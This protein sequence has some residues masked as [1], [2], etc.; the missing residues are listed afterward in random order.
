[1][2][3]RSEFESPNIVGT[4][5]RFYGYNTVE[6]TGALSDIDGY[7]PRV[8]VNGSSDSSRY[9]WTLKFDASDYSSSYVD[10]EVLQ[11]KALTCLMCIKT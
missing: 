4:F 3:L 2:W 10:D 11:P 5:D 9:A 1:M 7:T 6:H 8:G